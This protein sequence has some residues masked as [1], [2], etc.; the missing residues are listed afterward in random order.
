MADAGLVIDRI[1]AP[2]R[3]E[4]AEQIAAFIGEFRRSEQID[5]VGAGLG[6][7]L[8]HLVT[9]LVDGLVPGDALPLAVDELHRIFQT[10][11]AMDQLTHRRTLGA[12]RAAIDRAIPGWLLADPDAILDFGDYGAADRAMRADVLPDVRR[13]A[14]DFRPGLRLAHRS[15][16][17]QAQCGARAGS[18][19]GSA[20]K[21]A[22]VGDTAPHAGGAGL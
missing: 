19:T 7:D 21:G 20:Q 8:E 18:E 17:H 12:V 9:D 22:P 3:P 11:V 15:E 14:D 13:R 2:E 4:L 10:P 6:A 5:R 1:G 16:R